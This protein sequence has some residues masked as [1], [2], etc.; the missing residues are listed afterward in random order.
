MKGHSQGQIR[1]KLSGFS[2]MSMNKPS[3]FV[4][5]TAGA[6]DFFR[7]GLVGEARKKNEPFASQCVWRTKEVTQKAQSG[8]NWVGFRST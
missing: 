2:I 7:A 6:C 3:N 1:G 4:V 8:G 5:R